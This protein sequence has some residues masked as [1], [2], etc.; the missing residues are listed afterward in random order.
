M[1]AALPEEEKGALHTTCFAPL[2]LI[3]PI[4]MMSTLVV[5]ILNCHLGDMKFQFGG[6]IIQMKPIYVCLILGICV[7]PIVNEFLFVDPEHMTN[8]RMRRFPKEKNTFGL[9]EIDD[10][11]KQAKLERHNVR[12][13]TLPL[14][15]T[16]LLG[17]FQFSTPEKTVYDYIRL[18]SAGLFLRIR[19]ICYYN[20]PILD[21][22]TC[23][24]V[25]KKLKAEEGVIEGGMVVFF[26]RMP[27]QV[28]SNVL[29]MAKDGEQ[30][31]GKIML[32][33]IGGNLLCD[34]VMA[35]GWERGQAREYAYPI[36]TIVSSCG[37]EDVRH[38]CKLVKTRAQVC[39]GVFRRCTGCCTLNILDLRT[40]ICIEDPEEPDYEGMG[41]AEAKEDEEDFEF[42]VKL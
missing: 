36:E 41:E 21:R 28:W 8:F 34:R 9:K 1:F 15:D 6:T 33:L 7:S 17:Q 26:R 4:A 39:N 11:L 23:G 14:G 12:D 30:P 42:C 22:S 38:S 37:T 24:C 18:H 5:E 31:E 3:D 2:L 20:C 40:M 13:S 35:L 27:P 19:G 29:S 16:L 10:A 32:R 25:E